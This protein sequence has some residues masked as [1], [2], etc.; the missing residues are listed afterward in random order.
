MKLEG[1]GTVSVGDHGVQVGGQVDDV[2]GTEG[3]LLGADTTTDTSGSM[4]LLATH[5][6]MTMLGEEDRQ[7]MLTAT[8]K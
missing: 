3:A 2:D 7:C 6:C 5:S 1:V 4:T 8:R